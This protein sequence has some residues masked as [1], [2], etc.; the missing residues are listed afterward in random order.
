MKYVFTIIID[1]DLKSFK[2]KFMF[3]V[4]TYHLGKSY[5]TYKL[6]NFFI[7]FEY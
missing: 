4:G 5:C 6:I 1:F 3:K 7:S 2:C